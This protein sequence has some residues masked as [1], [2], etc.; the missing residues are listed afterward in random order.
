MSETYGARFLRELKARTQSTGGLKYATVQALEGADRAAFG[1]I[2]REGLPGL[3]Y[4]VGQMIEKD[5]PESVAR[6]FADVLRGSDLDPAI[7][8]FFGGLA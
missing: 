4:A 1:R 5:E 7:V 8:A 6:W 3:P 2:L